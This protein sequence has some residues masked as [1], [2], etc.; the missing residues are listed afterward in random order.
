LVDQETWRKLASDFEAIAAGNVSVERGDTGTPTGKVSAEIRAISA[1]ALISAAQIYAGAGDTLRMMATYERVRRDF[2]DLPRATSEVALAQGRIAEARRDWAAAAAAYESVI[3]RIEPR[4]GEAGV[5]GAVLEL[6]LRAARL[7]V[8]AAADTSFAARKPLYAGAR[9]YYE[10]QITRSPGSAV[11]VESRIHL[12]E[13]DS[14]VGEWRQAVG[15]LSDAEKELATMDTPPWDPA[16]VRFAIGRIQTQWQGTAGPG[17]DTFESLV[18]DYPDTRSAPR[19]L[20]A[21]SSLSAQDGDVESA[22]AYLD[23]VRDTYSRAEDLAAQALFARGTILQQNDRWGEALKVFRSLPAEHPVSEP[24]LRAP[25]AIVAH[26]TQVTDTTAV[27]QELERAEGWYREFLARYPSSPATVSARQKLVQVL[28]L[29]ERYGD[30]VQELVG[31]GKALG[32]SP[33]GAQFLL[34]AAR[35]SIVQLADTVRTVDIL[36]YT[37]QLFSN[38]EVGRWALSEAKRLRNGLSR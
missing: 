6:P 9:T 8:K 34:A 7:R 2:E 3:Q 25:L 38:A 22:L 12:A 14:D 19:A 31:L 27:A 5:A 30:A 15:G 28:S 17:R 10:G 20:I 37:G 4:P 11:A 16:E 29:Q 35:M 33:Q 21:L 18:A 13:V 23:R 1:R 36:E 24:A 26:Y 32:P